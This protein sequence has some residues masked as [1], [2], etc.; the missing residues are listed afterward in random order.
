MLL[1]VPLE[2]EVKQTV[3]AMNPHPAPGPDGFTGL[4]YRSF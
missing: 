3:F 1:A 2:D 4:F